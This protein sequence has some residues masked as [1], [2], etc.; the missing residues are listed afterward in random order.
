MSDEDAA[1]AMRDVLGRVRPYAGI[2]DWRVD[3]QRAELGVGEDFANAMNLQFGEEFRNL[4][5]RERGDDPPGLEAVDAHSRRIAIEVTEI[6]DSVA[7]QRAGGSQIYRHAAWAEAKLTDYVRAALLRKGGI[8]LKGGPYHELILVMFT[9][10]YLL[11]YERV[12]RWL[13]GSRFD[14]PQQIARAYVSC[15]YTPGHEYP[16]VPVL[17]H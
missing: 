16:L 2:R 9:G 3:R 12:S 5:S 8:E 1:A 17:W 13:S 6:V 15:D 7:I 4:K 11:D 10:E 14:R